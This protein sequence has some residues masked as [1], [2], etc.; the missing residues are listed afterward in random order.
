MPAGAVQEAGCDDQRTLRRRRARHARS[1][2]QRLR[3]IDERAASAGQASC[4]R[5]PHSQELHRH[6]LPATVTPEKPASASVR[7]RG[8][9]DVPRPVGTGGG[10]V[11]LTRL[12]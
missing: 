8:N 6:R 2:Q 4:P 7:R 12:A 5:I 11:H 9:G 3:R 1:P 10:L